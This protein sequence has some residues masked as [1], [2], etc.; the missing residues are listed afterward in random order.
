MT[1]RTCLIA[2]LAAVLPAMAEAQQAS[3]LSA[4]AMRAG[5]DSGY[6]LV[7]SYGPGTPI[8]VQG[9][10]EGYAWCDVIGPNG[11]RGWVYAGAI[12]YPLPTS[13]GSV[14]GYGAA[15]APAKTSRSGLLGRTIRIVPGTANAL[16][17]RSTSR[18]CR[19][20]PVA[21]RSSFIRCGPPSP[22]W[23]GGW[24]PPTPDR[25]GAGRGSSRPE[26]S[27]AAACSDGFRS[28]PAASTSTTAPSA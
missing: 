14:L 26:C 28:S 17:G 1:F 5:P 10:V 3:T 25:A 11:Y 19:P 16:A 21:G 13:P 4:V 24:R 18:S 12:G 9:C 27:S 7:A 2:A 6:P 22:R 23:R 15:I 8:T 20:V